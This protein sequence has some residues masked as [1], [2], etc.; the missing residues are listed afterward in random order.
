MSLEKKTSGGGKQEE[1]GN[2][3]RIKKTKSELTTK[4]NGF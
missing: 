2:C 4:I 1:E 3:S